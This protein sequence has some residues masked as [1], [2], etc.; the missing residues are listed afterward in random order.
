MAAVAEEL[1]AAE[2]LFAVHPAA[3][4]ALRVLLGPDRELEEVAV[5]PG[6]E[7]ALHLNDDG[8][9]PHAVGDHESAVGA[10]GCFDQVEA[11]GFRVGQRFLHKQMF[12]AAQQVDANGMVEVVRHG[13]DGGVDVVEDLAVVGRDGF[14]AHQVGG[15]LRARQVRVDRGGKEG[16]TLQF[17]KSRAVGLTHASAADQ[18]DADHNSCFQWLVFGFQSFVAAACEQRCV[19]FNALFIPA[20]IIP[21]AM[22]FR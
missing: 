22:R 10:L 17:L 11:F 4:L 13:E 21:I 14:A 2:R 18:A 9:K 7:Q 3:R 16:A 6:L 15:C 19:P 1:A 5:G 8:V 20:I 12:A